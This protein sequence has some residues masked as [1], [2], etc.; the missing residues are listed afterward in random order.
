MDQHYQQW[1]ELAPRGLLLIGAGASMIAQ[2]ASLRVKGRS[3]WQW[4][5]M[6]TVGLVVLNSG[7]SVF[8]ESI[9]HRAMYE[10]KL[11]L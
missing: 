4:V 10:H 2:A 11:G 1:S 9:K 3:A 8:G 6:G 7:V 5:V